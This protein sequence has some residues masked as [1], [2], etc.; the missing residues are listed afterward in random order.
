M[1]L[2]ALVILVGVG[3]SPQLFAASQDPEFARVAGLNVRLYNVAIAVLAAVSVTVAMRTVGLL[4]VET[5]LT[6]QVLRPGAAFWAPEGGMALFNYDDMRKADSPKD[7]LL[8]FLESAY[9]AGAKTAGWNIEDFRAVP[10][11]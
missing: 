8:D 3:L 7:A 5:G 10:L 6:D 11:V 2:A 9:Q 4:L 1:V